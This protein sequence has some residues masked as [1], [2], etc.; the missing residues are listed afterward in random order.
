MEAFDGGSAWE[1]TSDDPF[2]SLLQPVMRD[3]ELVAAPPTVDESRKRCSQSLQEMPDEVLQNDGARAFP[4]GLE[5]SLLK[6]KLAL[7]EEARRESS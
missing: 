2:E 7:I 6:M 4:V 5:T 3:G 1:F